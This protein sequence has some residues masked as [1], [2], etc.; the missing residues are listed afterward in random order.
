[1]HTAFSKRSLTFRSAKVATQEVVAIAGAKFLL[2]L[3]DEF[4][5]WVL[6]NNSNRPIR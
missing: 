5:Q 6:Q 1:M 2:K 4:Y 3:A